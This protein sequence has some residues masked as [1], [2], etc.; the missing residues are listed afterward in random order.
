[1][2]R[3]RVI[4]G[5][6]GLAN[7]PPAD[8]KT[9]WWK[10]AIAE[11]IVR[12]EGIPEPEFSFDFVYWADLRYEAPLSEASNHE[13]YRPYDGTGPLADG[14]DAPTLT[15]QDVLAPVYAGIDAVEEAT[16]LTLLDDA[17]LEHR[18]DD[19]W[20]YHA[21]QDFARRVRLRLSERL[22][23]FRNHRILLV[24]HS[25][26]SVVA[27]DV[28]RTLEREEPGLVIDH[29]VTAASPLGLAKVKL[30]FEAEHGD[31][32]VPDNVAAWTNL[33]DSGDVVTI[34]GALSADYAPNAGGV[35]ITDRRVVNAYRR[36]DGK[37][38]PHKSYGYLRVPEFSTLAAPYAVA[39]AGARAAE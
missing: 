13:P 23:R 21:E 33:A 17:I 5:I 7:K 29:L 4:V 11:G 2:E 10:A 27:Y 15:T 3:G 1:M 28:L 12:N 14:E 20:H 38:N 31:L 22:T 34:M 37:P 35:A 36:P 39:R 16:G 6:H 9:R 18:F 8:E 32:R 24:A 19:L 30:K 26:G 25:M